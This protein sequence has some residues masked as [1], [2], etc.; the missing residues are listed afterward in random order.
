M[1]R[2]WYEHGKMLEKRNTFTDFI[3]VAQHLV[4]TDITRPENQVAYGGSAG[5]LLVGA[6]A[7]FW[8]SRAHVTESRAVTIAP[9]PNG[10]AATLTAM[11]TKKR[12]SRFASQAALDA[13]LRFNPQLRAL[14]DIVLLFW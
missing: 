4:D 12:P 2:L 1:G 14:A 9:A 11:G 10:V 5:G 8:G 6:V 13:M 7:M 3:T